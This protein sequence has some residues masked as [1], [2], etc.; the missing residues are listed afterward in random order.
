MGQWTMAFEHPPQGLSP[1]DPAEALRAELLALK[2]ASGL[3]YARLGARTHYA[4]SSWERWINGKQFPPRAAVESL[5]EAL[6][7]DPGRLLA[8]WERAD[9]ARTDE[10]G[11][12]E[13]RTDSVPVPVDDSAGARSGEDSTEAGAPAPLRQR[14]TGRRRLLLVGALC[15]LGA[16]VSVAAVLATDGDSHGTRAA[17]P[18][19]S[20]AADSAAPPAPKCKAEGCNGKSPVTTNCGL[21]G[22]TLALTRNKN[23]V[24]ELRY[25]KACAA[26][27]GRITY[28][29]K[30]AIVDADN[31]AGVSFAT[32]VHWGNDVYSP[33]VSV[34]GR[35]T[36]WACGTLP[37]GGARECTRHMP[38]PGSH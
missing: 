25:S 3:S 35:M 21:D 16:A 30:S 19:P 14:L 12:D 28:A 34:T 24:I 5:A 8:L 1:D 33:M 6:E 15:L 22:Q 20:A 17:S 2:Q 38:V 18:K 26:A 29:S 13:V 23:M 37:K 31:S 11:T 7:Q 36:V 32:P 4:K 10:A 9:E 27:W